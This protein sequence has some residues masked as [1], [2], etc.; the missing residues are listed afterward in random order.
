[1][2]PDM[3]VIKVNPEPYKAMH[4]IETAKELL[5]SAEELLETGDYESA[6]G[7]ALNAMRMASSAL[8]FLDGQIAQTLETAVEYIK[9]THSK[10]PVDEWRD[11]EYQDPLKKGILNRLFEIFGIRKSDDRARATKVVGVARVFILSI[12]EEIKGGKQPGF[13]VYHRYE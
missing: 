10:I 11:A 5:N 4:A 7:N 6:Y 13:E 12:D 2:A 8:M 1:M 9:N 3:G